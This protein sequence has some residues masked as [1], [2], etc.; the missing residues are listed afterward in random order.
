MSDNPKMSR[1]RKKNDADGMQFHERRESDYMFVCQG[2]KSVCL[3]NY[4]AVLVMKEY[5]LHRHFD[6]K[7]V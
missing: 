5:N 1:K 7:Q 3:L 4:K 2:E 6:A